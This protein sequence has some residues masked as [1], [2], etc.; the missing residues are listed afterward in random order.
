MRIAMQEFEQIFAGGRK[1][2]PDDQVIERAVS[3]QKA[4]RKRAK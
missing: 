4:L 3:R 1:G 2:E